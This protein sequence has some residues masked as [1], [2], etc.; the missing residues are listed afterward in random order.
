MNIQKKTVNGK[1]FA[2]VESGQVIITE[3]QSALDFM[4]T[5]RYEMDCAGVI[6][7]KAA[8]CEDFFV[9]SSGIAGEILQKFSNYRL[10]FGIYGDF[11]GYTSKP[12]RDFMYESNQ[13]RQVAFSATAEDALQLLAK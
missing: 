7:N 5:M 2:V 6:L 1:T 3:A 11:S 12:L 9:L 8:L 10:V 13:G 4:M